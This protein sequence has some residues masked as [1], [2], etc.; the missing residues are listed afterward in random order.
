M[1]VPPETAGGRSR[2]GRRVPPGSRAAA[3]AELRRGRQ[4]GEHG[5]VVRRLIALVAIA[6]ATLPTPASSA[7]VP[8][9]VVDGRGFGHGVGMA[10]DGAYWMGV[11]GA[12]TD[13][14]LGQFYPGTTIGKGSGPV[15]VA[16]GDVGP[17]PAA[18]VLA[19]PDGG[20]LRDARSG[21]QSDGFPISVPKGGV[22]RVV[23]HEQQYAVGRRCRVARLHHAFVLSPC[24]RR[25]PA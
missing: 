2:A 22:V 24:S 19:F 9:L 4:R 5:G 16:V 10:Q 7:S 17:T 12:R 18:V 8:V 13:Q 3:A 23:L 25:R 21:D 11:G 14:I 20:E 6:I 15:R 1:Q